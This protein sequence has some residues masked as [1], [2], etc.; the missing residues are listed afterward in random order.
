VRLNAEGDGVIG[1]TSTT[2]IP[3][4]QLAIVPL[5][6]GPAVTVDVPSS[7]RQ[8]L[9]LSPDGSVVLAEYSDEATERRSTWLFDIVSGDGKQVF[10][11]SMSNSSWQRLAP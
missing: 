8:G 9:K 3:P 5:D 10:W 6:G 4:G 11:P 1:K 2:E 7:G